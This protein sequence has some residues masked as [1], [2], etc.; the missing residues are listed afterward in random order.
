MVP[1]LQIPLRCVADR[2]LRI[3][4]FDGG[5]HKRQP[6]IGHVFCPLAQVVADS[7]A[8][9]AAAAATNVANPAIVMARDLVR[10]S[11]CSCC[12]STISLPDG[13]GLG[14]IRRNGNYITLN[15]IVITNTNSYKKL[16]IPSSP[17]HIV[18]EIQES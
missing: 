5:R 17:A 10:V 3:S 9:A 11:C 2:T 4:V 6:A 1:P 14:V 18:L 8:N 16:H 15:G 13:R 12:I 7:V